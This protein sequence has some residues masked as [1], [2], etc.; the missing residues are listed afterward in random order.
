MGNKAE[1]F[2]R[3]RIRHSMNQKVLKGMR[4]RQGKY[5]Y[6][7]GKEAKAERRKQRREQSSRQFQFNRA[8]GNT[9]NGRPLEDIIDLVPENIVYVLKH[10]DE[11]E[12]G[13]ETYN[14]EK[15]T[16]VSTTI[17]EFTRRETPS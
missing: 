3:V 7:N 1:Q 11:H 4:E 2:S 15:G 16:K 8:L 13:I 17:V 14:T 10:I 9:F 5:F 12:R 6:P